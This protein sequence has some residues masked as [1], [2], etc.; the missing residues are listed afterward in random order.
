[1]KRT[2]LCAATT[3]VAD[4]TPCV[5][6]SCQLLRLLLRVLLLL[7]TLSDEQHQAAQC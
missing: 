1:M 6:A 5:G 3:A 7:S 2:T 4:G